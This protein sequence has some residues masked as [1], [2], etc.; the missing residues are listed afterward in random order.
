MN[1]AGNLESRVSPQSSEWAIC[2][3][4]VAQTRIGSIDLLR[5]LVMVLMALDHTRDF[6]G[7]SGMNP[8]D[9]ADPAL[10]LTRWITHF[11]APTFIFLAG[12]SA[13]L[14]GTRAHSLG[15]LSRF[16]L[17]RGL[18]LVLLELTVVRFGWRFNVDL[19]YFV[20]QVIWVIGASM[21]VLAALVYMPRWA[22]A[23]I[24]LGMIGGHNLLDGVR[25][26]DLARAGW[27]WNFLH[28]PALVRAGNVQ[29]FPLYTLIPWV[30]VMAAGYAMGPVMRLEKA[31]R[32]MLLIGIGTGITVGFVLLRTVNLYGDP[33]A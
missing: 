7:A 14:Y 32:R 3:G 20:L 15:E 8:R 4:D 25:A 24:G 5:G 2:V 23:T 10:F 1:V 12:V 27:V 6:F 18:W 22:I 11:C 26:E 17:T 30:G 28:Q 29:V 13:Y 33:V 21:I 9:V 19:S 31:R 16:L